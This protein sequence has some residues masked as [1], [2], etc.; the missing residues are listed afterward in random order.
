MTAIW[1]F[2]VPVQDELV[3]QMP[4]GAQV[5]CVQLQFDQPHVWALVDP[6]VP[7]TPRRFAWRG[8][9]HTTDG[10]DAEMY[11]GTIQIMAGA[12]IFHLFDRD[13]GVTLMPVTS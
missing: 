2:A 8:T 11:I 7:A 13:A 3:V 4:G 9:G 10:L 1:K 5:L 12:L 6:A